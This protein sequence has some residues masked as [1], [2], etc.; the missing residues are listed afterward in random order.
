MGCRSINNIVDATNYILYLYGQ[1]LHAFDYDKLK[2]KSGKVD[3]VVR[4]AKDGEKFTT[5]DDEKRTLT[6]DMTV[7]STKEKAVALAGVMGGQNSEV[8]DKT[9]SIL[10]ETATFSPAHTSRTSRNL[11]LI[12][13]S[14]MR[15]ERR[16]DDADI[17][18]ISDASVALII[19]L[20]G[21]KVCSVGGTAKDSFVDE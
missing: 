18:S 2:D 6:S 5:L 14:S 19:E 1:P 16:V 7:I 17:K 4:A 15:Y 10:L 13:E 9:T 20:A 21:G 12:S 8:T 11:G 3:I